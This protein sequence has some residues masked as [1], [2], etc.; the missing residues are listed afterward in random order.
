MLASLLL[1]AGASGGLHHHQHNNACADLHGAPLASAPD[2]AT[3]EAYSGQ[4]DASFLSSREKAT[5]LLHCPTTCGSTK[6][7]DGGGFGYCV[8]TAGHDSCFDEPHDCETRKP[9]TVVEHVM[10]RKTLGLCSGHGR[11]ADACGDGYG[12]V[13]ELMQKSID[14]RSGLASL[15]ATAPGLQASHMPRDPVLLRQAM[16]AL[17]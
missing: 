11:R 13:N 15:L 10:C 16:Q 8:Y 9:T 3:C 14:A 12:E 1:L 17:K 2:L 4:C 5:L 6:Y 7:A